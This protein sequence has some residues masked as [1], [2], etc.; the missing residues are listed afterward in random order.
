VQIRPSCCDAPKPPS[1]LPTSFKFG[2]SKQRLASSTELSVKCAYRM[3][4][5][6][7]V[8]FGSKATGLNAIGPDLI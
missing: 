3:R 7:I 1:T 8:W 2:V 4:P 5:I 6:T